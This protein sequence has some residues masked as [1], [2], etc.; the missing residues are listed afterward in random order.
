MYNRISPR[1][2]PGPSRINESKPR[3]D[4]TPSKSESVELEL[5]IPTTPPPVEN[6]LAARRAKRL[7]I[8][9]KYS[10]VASVDA[11]PSPSSAVQPPTTSSHVSDPVTRALSVNGTPG[12]SGIDS[13]KSMKAANGSSKLR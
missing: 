6:I 2:S 12:P 5:E 9:A 13:T 11:T 8:L 7:A 10:G 4:T 3:R 1:H